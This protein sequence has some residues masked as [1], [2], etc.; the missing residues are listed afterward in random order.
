MVSKM[1]SPVSEEA[2]TVVG[3]FGKLISQTC[4]EHHMKIGLHTSSEADDRDDR[5][6]EDVRLDLVA[7][8]SGL[9]EQ[10]TGS[11]LRDSSP[12]YISNLNTFSA[13][14][15]R[16]VIENV[17][18]YQLREGD[19]VGHGAQLQERISAVEYLLRLLVELGFAYN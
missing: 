1:T 14:M 15:D 5:S 16:L 12:A 17:K 2:T 8:F 10:A 11:T 18:L 6:I 9:R 13:L 19:L 3:L 7:F 4:H